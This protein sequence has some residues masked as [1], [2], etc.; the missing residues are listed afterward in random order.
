MN[1]SVTG[2]YHRD[3]LIKKFN[4]YLQKRRP[5]SGFRHAHIR[6]FTINNHHIR[7]S[8]WSLFQ[9]EKVTVL[10][11]PPYSPDLAPA[12]FFSFSKTWK[13][14]IWSSLPLAQRPVSASEVYLPQRTATHF[15]SILYLSRKRRDRGGYWPKIDLRYVRSCTKIKSFVLNILKLRYFW[16]QF[17]DLEVSKVFFKVV[18]ISKIAS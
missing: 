8:L 6:Y 17:L 10:P 9:S 18:L 5:V 2:R 15:K 1:K 12:L 3:V 4:K 13:V 16:E 7:L 14:L 11:H